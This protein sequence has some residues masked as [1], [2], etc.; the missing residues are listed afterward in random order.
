MEMTWAEWKSVK[1]LLRRKLGAPGWT[2]LLYYLILNVAVFLWIL[3][4]TLFRMGPLLLTGDFAA[5]E[6]AALA[7]SESGW[8]YF[9]GAAVG[10]LILLLWKKPRYLKKEIFAKGA[11]M[12][13]SAFLA[14]LCVFLG[15]QF[16]S[17]ISLALMEVI[18]NRFDLTIIE[19]LEALSVDPGNF[20]MF[21]YAGILAPITEEI[22]FRG[23]VQRSMMPYGRNFAIFVS[24]LTFGLF[25]GNLVQ[26]PFAFLVGLVLGYVAA[27]Y[28]VLW[29]MVLHMIN[30]MLVADSF[31][32]LTASL[33]AEAAG[34]ILW[35]FLFL[36]AVAGSVIL[37]RNRNAIRNWMN[38]QRIHRTYLGCYF[39]SFGNILFILLMVLMMLGTL[40]VLITP[41]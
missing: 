27:E 8:G 9:L 38:Q 23:L 19:G 25:H 31:N 15:C 1:K 34:M 22:L 33:P 40:F 36:C 37:L 14:I 13:P 35:G 12:R 26:A 32:R 5:M 18:L 16:L 39:T 30:N 7:A 41:L 10:F 29:A 24:S 28:S 2:L 4:E 21:L 17:Q 11:P 20:S 6:Q 3:G